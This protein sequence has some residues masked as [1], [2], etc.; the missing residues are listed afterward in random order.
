MTTRRGVVVSALL[1]TLAA[2]SYAVEFRRQPGSAVPPAGVPLVSAP[3]FLQGGSLPGGFSAAP[4]LLGQEAVSLGA[5]ADQASLVPAAPAPEA[6]APRSI[7]Q[8]QADWLASQAEPSAQEARSAEAFDGVGG[9]E[10][11]FPL[12]PDSLGGP[13]F[14]VPTRGEAA[15]IDTARSRA[16]QNS[17]VFSSL[18]DDFRSQGGYVQVYHYPNA[19]AMSWAG[20]DNSGRPVVFLASDLL[21]RIN[22][23]R[24]E[25][26]YRGAPWE[27]IAATMAKDMVLSN[28]WYYA[29]PASADKLAVAAMNLVRVFVD[30]TNGTSSSWAT[31]K[32]FQHQ[33]G[34]SHSYIAWKWFD[35]LR[36]AAAAAVAGGGPGILYHSG[37]LAWVRDHVAS[38]ETTSP[39]YGFTLWERYDGKY[40]R[41]GDALNGTPIPDHVSRIDKATF[42]RESYKVYGADGKSND[43]EHRLDNRTTFGWIIDW[44]KGRSEV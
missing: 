2:N 33:P 41:P 5:L 10:R 11:F 1:M 16:S 20:H 25:D 4:V 40:Y 23:P 39:E 9:P 31:D 32:D 42:D 22:G 27:L 36:T 26:E 24:T 21:N 34:D 14:S 3:Q 7:A 19:P 8:V 35:S 44:L 38:R 37:F 13:Q 17:R 6:A 43:K 15:K 30:L 29:I 28:R 12:D 18:N